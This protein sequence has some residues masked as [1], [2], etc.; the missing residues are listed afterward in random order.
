MADGMAVAALSMNN[1]MQ[2][3]SSISHN[4]TNA[5]TPG[6]K[7]E[8]SFMSVL[9]DQDMTL[10]NTN[11]SAPIPQLSSV[12][13][14]KPAALRITGNPLDVAIE[15]QGFFEVQHDGQTF[16]TRQGNFSLDANGQLRNVAGDTVM[17]LAG[18]LQLSSSQPSID[19][20]GKIL[21]NGKLVG[22]LK[23]VNFVDP[24]LLQSVGEGKFLQGSAVLKNDGSTLVR[25]GHLEASNVNTAA[26]II[27]MIEPMRHFETGQKIIQMYDDMTERAISKLGEF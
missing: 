1:D 17:G 11:I 8:M 23:V 27:K 4:L 13:D 21:E 15:N 24:S 14:M 3:M 10:S 9:S 18:S 20:S 16:Y 26:E 2:R 22:Q 25:Q 6:Y 12:T 19:R 5:L 7:R